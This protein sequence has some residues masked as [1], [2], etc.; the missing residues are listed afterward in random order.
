MLYGLSGLPSL[1]VLDLAN[2]PDLCYMD[3]AVRQVQMAWFDKHV[4]PT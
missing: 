3:L 1:G 4:K 2:M